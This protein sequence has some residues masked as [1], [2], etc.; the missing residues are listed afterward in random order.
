[1]LVPSEAG[2][3]VEVD[4]VWMRQEKCSH[5]AA[6]IFELLPETSP[7]GTPSEVWEV[8]WF[9]LE[10]ASPDT[11]TDM[12]CA[13]LSACLA[14][15]ARPRTFDA[16]IAGVNTLALRL[17]IGGARALELYTESQSSEARG[18]SIRLRGTISSPTT[19][20]AV[21]AAERVGSE[22][23]GGGLA[24]GIFS[25]I[26]V[27]RPRS[28]LSMTIDGQ[29][30]ELTPWA[31]GVFPGCFGELPADMSEMEKEAYRQG[32]PDKAVERHLRALRRLVL[33][34]APRAAEVRNAC[35][36]AIMA[37]AAPDYGLALTL[38]FTVV[39][40]LLLEA[41]AKDNVLA[42]LTE[43]IAHSLGRT[44]EERATLRKVA[45]KLYE[46]RSGFV[47]TGTADE[48][49]MGRSNAIELMTHVLRREIQALD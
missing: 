25:W 38:A 34:E 5:L 28:R 35:R 45:K 24:L 46:H 18:P 37:I 1:M 4:P 49:P 40:G 43:A 15:S 26:D 48:T 41:E 47:H 13:L 27:R 31:Q 8:L 6:Q 30:S 20:G 3:A 14:D 42:R 7:F 11:S 9:A 16:P 2:S 12:L 17:H 21:Y 22:I 10:K 29:P 19:D 36:T 23:V 44:A 32:H 33:S 39:E